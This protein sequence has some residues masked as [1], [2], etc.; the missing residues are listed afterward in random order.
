METKKIYQTP[1][2]E[3]INAEVEYRV[4]SGSGLTGND[5]GIGIGYGGSDDGTGG[6]TPQAKGFGESSNIWSEDE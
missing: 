1:I 5:G 3:I 4:S 2:T 6:H